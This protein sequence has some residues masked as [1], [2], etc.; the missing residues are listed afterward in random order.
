[1]WGIGWRTVQKMLIDAPRYDFK[2]GKDGTK[3]KA[4]KAKSLRD[5]ANEMMNKQ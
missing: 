3:P 1:M 4:Q 5:F 2:K